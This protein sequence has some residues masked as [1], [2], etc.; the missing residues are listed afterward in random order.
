[1]KSEKNLPGGMRPHTGQM[2]IVTALEVARLCGFFKFA[3]AVPRNG[4]GDKHGCLPAD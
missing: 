3:F 1:M 4:D 2:K